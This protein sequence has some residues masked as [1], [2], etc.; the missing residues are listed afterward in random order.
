LRALRTGYPAAVGHPLVVR[1]TGEQYWGVSRLGFRGGTNAGAIWTSLGPETSI[2]DPSS[3]SSENISG[4]VAALAVSPTLHASGRCRMWVAT[5]GGGFWRHWTMRSTPT[6]SAGAGLSQGVGTNNTGSL[7]LDPNDADRQH[8]LRSAPARPTRRTTPAPGTGVYRSTNG[9]DV[10]TRVS[11]MNH[12]P[13]VSSQPIDF[14]YTR[15]ISAVVVPPGSPQTIYVATTT[16]ILGMTA[17]AWRAGAEQRP[18]AAAA[19]A[20]Q[21][22]QRRPP[23]GRW[24]GS[25][26]QARSSFRIPTEPVASSTR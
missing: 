16:A 6:M 12:D 7:G 20:L 17:G 3:G 15:G 18:A 21:D 22:R 1:A 8:D 26:P 24:R 11:T 13:V 19:G 5:A 14:T 25:P 9:G 4:R 2:Q 23:V 10:W